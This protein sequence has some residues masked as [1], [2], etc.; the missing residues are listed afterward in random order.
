MSTLSTGLVVV[1]TIRNGKCL[2]DPMI[3]IGDIQYKVDSAGVSSTVGYMQYSM[4]LVLGRDPCVSTAV[5]LKEGVIY[6]SWSNNF[7]PMSL[8]SILYKDLRLRL[9]FLVERS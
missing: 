4:V 9:A 3:F 5:W 6:L 1:V 7:F 2:T 8:K